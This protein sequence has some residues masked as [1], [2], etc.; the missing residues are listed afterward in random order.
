MLQALQNICLKMLIDASSKH[1]SQKLNI[2]NLEWSEINFCHY[3]KQT[4]YTQ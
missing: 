4:F 1:N 2:D 3:A